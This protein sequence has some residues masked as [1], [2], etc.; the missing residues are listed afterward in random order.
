M[1]HAGGNVTNMT[2]KLRPNKTRE[3]IYGEVYGEIYDGNCK[4]Q[5]ETT[6]KY[7]EE[8]GSFSMQKRRKSNQ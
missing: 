1:P 6:D 4:N 5:R 7:M 3:A 8:Y 2:P